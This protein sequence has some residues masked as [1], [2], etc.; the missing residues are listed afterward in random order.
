MRMTVVPACSICNAG[1][2]AIEEEFRNLVVM[3]AGPAAAADTY[4]AFVRSINR[5]PVRRSQIVSRLTRSGKDLVYGE[6]RQKYSG[7]LI[8]MVKGLYYLEFGRPS[9][10]ITSL[11]RRSAHANQVTSTTKPQIRLRES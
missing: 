6:M 11:T 2:S 1:A 7:I 9:R 10:G 3:V 8:K 4:Q 5:L